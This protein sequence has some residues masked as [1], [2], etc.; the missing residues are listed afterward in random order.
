M[1]DRPWIAVPPPPAARRSVA[2][3]AIAPVAGENPVELAGHALM[4]LAAGG[5]R[6]TLGSLPFGGS[7]ATEVIEIIQ[8]MYTYAY[9]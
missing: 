5:I 7:E 4:G 3:A 9:N 2:D 6:L 1:D 8:H